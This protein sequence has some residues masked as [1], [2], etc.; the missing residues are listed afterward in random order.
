MILLDPHAAASFFVT[1]N[2]LVSGNSSIVVGSDNSSAVFLTGNAEVHAADIAVTGGSSLVGN[3]T[4]SGAIESGVAP[5][6]DPLRFLPPPDPAT[7]TVQATAR[8][9]ISKGSVMLEPGVYLGGIGISGKASVTMAPGI[10]YLAAGGLAVD[11]QASLDAEGV[12]IYNAG[13][14]QG[15]KLHLAGQGSVTLSPMSYGV[16]SGIT[17]FQDRNS[18]ANVELAVGNGVFQS[19]GTF[20][21]AAAQVKVSG[22]GVASLASQIIS[23]TF[24]AH[25]NG[26]FNL[27]WDPTLAP[28]G[29]K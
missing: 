24:V 6:G 29:C 5:V 23:D 13:S 10:Y 19:S 3:A 8:V 4:V 9:E 16:Y 2:G 25:G 14:G 28:V 11:G 1:G 22:N 18:T 7:L 27:T 20:Y 17:Y 21:S 12:M 15:D 26:D